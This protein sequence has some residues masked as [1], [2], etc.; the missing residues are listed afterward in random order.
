MHQHGICDTKLVAAGTMLIDRMFATINLF[1]SEHFL[2][3]LIFVSKIPTL[4]PA[5]S[6]SMCIPC[7]SSLVNWADVG[8]MA[9][10]DAG[11]FHYYRSYKIV[12]AFINSTSR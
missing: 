4:W 8:I 9:G 2:R 11:I 5:L 1:L 7:V 12:K 6:Q 3:A 10:T